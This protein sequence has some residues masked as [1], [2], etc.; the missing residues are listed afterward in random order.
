MESWPAVSRC[1]GNE[2][3]DHEGSCLEN[4][5]LNRMLSFILLNPLTR[6]THTA[7]MAKLKA[8]LFH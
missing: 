4:V 2:V 7:F 5:D 6:P 1:F 3:F 8:H